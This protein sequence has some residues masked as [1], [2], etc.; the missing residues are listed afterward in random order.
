M[1]LSYLIGK[2]KKSESLGGGGHR[3]QDGA[4]PEGSARGACAHGAP[5]PSPSER[6]DAAEGP[7][8]EAV[9]HSARPNSSR[10]SAPGA[11]VAGS[12][13]QPDTWGDGT[14]KVMGSDVQPFYSGTQA[15]GLRASGT[16]ATRRTDLFTGTNQ[17]KPPKVES[18][19]LFARRPRS[20]RRTGR[21]PYSAATT[22]SGR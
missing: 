5:R 19:A 8:A 7:G 10:V 4:G 9:A 16:I 15:P 14:P 13:P 18:E 11:R 2:P 6:D 17:M 21:S 1:A 12:P 3:R 20:G 22:A